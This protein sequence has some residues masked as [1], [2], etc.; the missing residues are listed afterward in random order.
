MVYDYFIFF[1]HGTLRF[2]KT[3]QQTRWPQQ[4]LHQSVQ[5]QAIAAEPYFGWN[6]KQIRS[7]Q[8]YY[9]AWA[10]MPLKKKWS[11]SAR[12]YACHGRELL[13]VRGRILY[14]VVPWRG[15]SCRLYSFR[16]QQQLLHALHWPHS[17]ISL[18]GCTRLLIWCCNPVIIRESYND[19]NVRILVYDLTAVRFFT[20]G[21]NTTGLS[22]FKIQHDQ[23]KDFWRHN[24]A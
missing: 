15:W 13:Q 14:F 18:H 4:D 12:R 8:H 19:K 2:I 7:V 21:W 22:I 5:I 11:S 16:T 20:R 23:T 24:T 17:L 9:K 3:A 10:H 1:W 6:Y